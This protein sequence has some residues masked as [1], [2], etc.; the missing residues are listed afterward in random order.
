MLAK[1]A[2]DDLADLIRQTRQ[3]GRRQLFAP[4][5]EKELAIHGQ[6]SASGVG[7]ST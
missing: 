7:S 5:F 6:T 1:L 4:D 2:A 3:P